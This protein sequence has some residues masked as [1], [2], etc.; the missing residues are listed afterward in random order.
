MLNSMYSGI[1]GLGVN[2]KKLDVNGNNISNSGTTAFKSSSVT[3]Q[4][5][6]YQNYRGASGPGLNLGGINP[7]RVG[8]GVSIQSIVTNTNQGSL[9]PTGRV[10]DMALD[11]A[12]GN[13]YFIV[14]K[15]DV[16]GNISVTTNQNMSSDN[17]ETFFTRDGSFRVDSKGN[18]LTANGYRIM[19]YSISDGTKACPAVT[20]NSVVLNAEGKITCNY[21]D[22][23][24][25]TLNA[26]QNNLIPLTIPETVLKPDKD[27]A[28]KTIEV[29]IQSFSV[30]GDGL[31]K[32]VLADGSSTVL[33]QVA[34]ASFNNNEGLQQVGN[35]M[36][37]P[38][39][40]S[41]EALVRV[42]KF[43]ST[44]G[45]AGHQENGDAYGSVLNGYLE[46]SNVDLS[47]QF[48]DM[49][50]AT[51]SFQACGKIITTADEILQELVNLKR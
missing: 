40:N 43:S 7:S 45:L 50:V 21:V 24:S 31:I 47:S 22:G 1:S 30:E 41:G 34:M 28:T 23:N 14:A 25:K 51:R 4:D 33:G 20:G 19:G 37:T 44:V 16:A 32:A 26:D 17:M 12:N 11:G 36:Y 42:G 38:S 49:I 3:F 8:M 35:N 39:A 6:M 15:G 13:S 27:D 29:R 5:N 9:S 10:Y 18:L 2:Q 46:M 48:T